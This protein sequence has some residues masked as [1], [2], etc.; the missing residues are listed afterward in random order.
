MIKTQ[1]PANVENVPNTRAP[2]FAFVSQS[3]SVINV[4]WAQLFEKTVDT[5]QIV[6]KSFIMLIIRDLDA[7]QYLD[8]FRSMIHVFKRTL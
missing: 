4:C 5:F 2:K 1:I 8:N 3:H 7:L 6:P